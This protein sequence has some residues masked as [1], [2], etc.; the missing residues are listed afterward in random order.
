MFCTYL[1]HLLHHTWLC[2]PHYMACCTS[3][4]LCILTV[5]VLHCHTSTPYSISHQQTGMP[6]HGILVYTY[7][8][9]CEFCYCRRG[10]VA[11]SCLAVLH[12]YHHNI[13]HFLSLKTKQLLH[14]RGVKK[15]YYILFLEF[16]G[17]WG[18]C[19]LQKL[20]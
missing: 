1:V 6:G 17:G 18:V 2:Y 7:Q 4:V 3:L 19:R 15:P 16:L 12:R 9:C 5:V 11:V 20:P 10:K 8:E 14:E 13:S